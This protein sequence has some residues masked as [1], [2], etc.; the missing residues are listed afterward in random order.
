MGRVV[1]SLLRLA[2][3]DEEGLEHAV[4]VPVQTLVSTAVERGR[5]LGDREFGTELAPEADVEVLGDREALDQVLLNLISNAVRHTQ[6]GGRIVCGTMR[7]GG[8]VGIYIADD[9]EGIPPDVLPSLFDRFTRADAARRRDT[10]GAGLGLAICRAIVEA[11][12]GIIGASSELGHGATFT[13]LLPVL[14]R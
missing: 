14:A 7:H 11:H 9:G 13:I 10:G 1:S 6:P 3:I 12:D 2:R 4:P 8:E 5:T